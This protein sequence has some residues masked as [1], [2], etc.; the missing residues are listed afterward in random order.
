MS[1]ATSPRGPKSSG[2]R[3]IVALLLI[4]VAVAIFSISFSILM[5]SES[6]PPRGGLGPG[7]SMPPIQAAGWINGTAPSPESLKGKVLVVDAWAYW[8]GPCLAEAPHLVSTYNTFHDRGV[9]FIGITMDTGKNILDM[10]RFLKDGKI[11]WP[12]AYGAGQTL[13]A[14]GVQGIP[15]VWVVGVDGKIRWNFDSEGSLDAAIE[16]ALGEASTQVAERVTEQGAQ[17]RMQP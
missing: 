3:S 9:V 14:L 1:Q 17:G 5:H 10:K 2:G 7:S 6:H 13:D 8:C 11:P 4:V 16:D 12:C 15:Q